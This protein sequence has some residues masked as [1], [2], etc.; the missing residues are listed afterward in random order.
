MS[1]S[2]TAP[3]VP[4]LLTDRQVGQ[5]L[6]VSSRLIWKLAATGELPRPLKIGRASRWRRE[7]VTAYVDRLA[8]EAAGK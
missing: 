3:L 5:A 7:D 1:I 4:L 6:G 2:V 8:A